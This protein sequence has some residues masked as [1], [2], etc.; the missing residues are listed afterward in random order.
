M[1]YYHSPEIS[2]ETEIP[3]ILMSSTKG[4]YDLDDIDMDAQYGGHYD[5]NGN[6]VEA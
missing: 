4:G 3:D 2:L 5:E 1:K 6:W